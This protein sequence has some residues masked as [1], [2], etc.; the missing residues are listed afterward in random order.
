MQILGGKV[1]QHP[2][3]FGI[4]SIEFIKVGKKRGRGVMQKERMISSIADIYFPKK[5]IDNLGGSDILG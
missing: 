1:V 5:P 4:S 3:H 2:T